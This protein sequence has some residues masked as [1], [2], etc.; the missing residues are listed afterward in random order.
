MRHLYGTC[1]NEECGACQDYAERTASGDH[2][3]EQYTDADLAYE[4]DARAADDW[5]RR[6]A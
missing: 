2:E 3:R 4:M 5:Y 6:S 1:R